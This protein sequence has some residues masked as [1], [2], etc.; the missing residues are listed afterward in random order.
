MEAL[1]AALLLAGFSGIEAAGGFVTARK[2]EWQAGASF[3]L[4]SRGAAAPAAPAAPNW[5][6][7]GEDDEELVEEE[8]LLTEEERLKRPSAD[9]CEVGAS[10]RKAC[11]NCSCG[12]AEAEAKV[13]VG[14]A[15]DL[16]ALPPSAC[17]SVRPRPPQSSRTSPLCSATWATPSAAPPA[18]TWE[19][20]PSSLARR[21]CSQAWA[22]MTSDGSCL[23]TA[24]LPLACHRL[25]PLDIK[26]CV[27]VSKLAVARRG[28]MQ[29]RA[30]CPRG[31]AHARSLVRRSFGTD[32][33]RSVSSL[34]PRATAEGR[35]L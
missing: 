17:G 2:P 4:K 14:D 31:S 19:R 10:G 11:A 18:P 27:V 3:S 30:A 1:R 26:S 21:W 8:G 32:R 35:L 24:P 15:V 22:W 13:K 28:L 5:A 33:L 34:K 23:A 16:S 6:V 29:S 20:P 12:R 25:F 7:S 9:D